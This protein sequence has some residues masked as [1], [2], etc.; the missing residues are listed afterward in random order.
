MKKAIRAVAIIVLALGLGYLGFQLAPKP[1]SSDLS[2]ISEDKPAVVLAYENFSPTGGEV[3]GRLKALRPDYE[4][5]LN[6]IVADLGTP[7][8]RAF[9]ERHGLVDGQAVLLSSEGR[10]VA[11]MGPMASDPFMRELFDKQLAAER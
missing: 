2:L 5:R 7:Q 1:M 11:V 4:A 3:L 9:G 10:A 6:F 8:G